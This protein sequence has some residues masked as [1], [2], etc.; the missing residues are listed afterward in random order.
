MEMTIDKSILYM[1]LYKQRLEESISDGLEEDIEAYDV[2]I[3]SMRKCQKIQTILDM[4]VPYRHFVKSMKLS[5][6][7]NVIKG[8]KQE[9]K[10]WKFLDEDQT[11]GYVD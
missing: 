10:F 11:N 4:D 1:S 8:E 5:A 3:T 9:D 2:A 6:I 7:Y